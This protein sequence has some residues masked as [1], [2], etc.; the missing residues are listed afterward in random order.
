MKVRNI[1][2]SLKC[3]KI[4][5]HPRYREHDRHVPAPDGR[6]CGGGNGLGIAYD[7]LCANDL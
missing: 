1:S 3:E 2:F 4:P 6:N 5:I 7:G